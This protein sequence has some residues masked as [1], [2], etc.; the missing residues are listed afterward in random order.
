MISS[1]ELKNLRLGDAVLA[2]VQRRVSKARTDFLQLCKS[3]EQVGPK[4]EWV[5][6]GNGWPNMVPAGNDGIGRDVILYDHASAVFKSRDYGQLALGTIVQVSPG[7]WR[8]IELPEIVEEGNRFPTAASFFPYRS[9]LEV[10]TSRGF[11][12]RNSKMAQLQIDLEKVDKQLSAARNRSRLPNW[13]EQ[14]AAIK[15]ES[16]SCLKIRT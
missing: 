5:H 10:R 1:T 16:S 3:Q 11:L 14:P 9:F 12:R 15:E 6:A 4:T 13:N 2:D 7:L 8:L